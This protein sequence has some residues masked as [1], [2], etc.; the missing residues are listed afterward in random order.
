[1]ADSK[2]EDKSPLRTS[3]IQQ[4]RDLSAASAKNSRL[5]R[6]LANYT[7]VLFVFGILQAIAIAFFTRGFLL[8][9][10]VLPDIAMCSSQYN[11]TGSESCFHATPE[12]QKAVI[13]VVDALRFDFT[14]PVPGS[15]EG[16]NDYNYHNQFGVFYDAFIN[17]PENSLLLKFIAD[18]PT[19]T[20]QRLKGLTTG[21]LPTFIDAGSNFDGDTI[22]EDNLIRQLYEH[23]KRIAFAGDDT[24]T[25]MFSPYLYSNLTYPFDSLNVW[26][27]HTVDNGV[28]DNVL[29]LLEHDRQKEWDVLIGHFL[30]VD[31]CGHRYGPEHYSMKDKLNQIDEIIRKVMESLD[32]DTLLVVFGDHGMDS[33][34]NHG[35]ESDDEVEAALFMYSKKK[36]FGRLRDISNYDISENGKNYRRVNQIDIVPSL[37]LALG[38]PI[39]FNN[40]GSPIDEMFIKNPNDLKLASQLT[41]H[42]INQYRMKSDELSN[43]EVV[44]SFFANV[45]ESFESNHQ[46]QKLS[47]ERCKS[48]WATFDDVNIWIGI[49]LLTIS[50]IV[51]IVYSKLVPTVVISQLNEQC[52]LASVVLILVYCVLCVSFKLIFNPEMLPMT[53][54]VL[55]GIA[56]GIANGILAPL[57]DRYSIPFFFSQLKDNLIQNGWTYTG[58]FIIG[59]HSLLFT[60]NSFIIWEDK[61]VSFWLGTIGIMAFYKSLQN[62]NKQS[63]ILGMYHSF[64]FVLLTRIISSITICREEQGDKCST[65]FSVSWNV[66]G[67]LLILSFALPAFIKGFFNQTQSYNGMA[68]ILI[69]KVLPFMMILTWS[70]WCLEFIGNDEY[71]NK[72]F[73]L[74]TDLLD[75][76]KLTLARVVVLGSLIGGNVGWHFLP[77]CMDMK[78]ENQ[79]VP[80]TPGDAN[81]DSIIK[82]TVILL[83]LENAYG[84]SYFLF[85][86]NWIVAILCVTK[87]VGQISLILFV[88]QILTFLEL[89]EILNIRINL[90]SVVVFG[91][92]GYQQFFTTGHQATLQ[93]INW[94]SGFMLTKE[95]TF[96]LT[97]L[98]ILL[99]T[100][101]PFILIG[102]AIPLLSLW[103]ISPTQ[104]PIGLVSRVVENGTTLLIYQTFLTLSTLVMSNHFRRHLM[105]WKIFAPRFMLNSMILILLNVVITCISIGYTTFNSLKRWNIA[106]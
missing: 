32:D 70:Y 69:F 51:L 4:K 9:R 82:K 25:A 14:I 2:Q 95:I 57:I 100:F 30:G 89:V 27:L 79:I 17:Q 49:G 105:V 58:V 66:I 23:N 26:D 71:L 44:N 106:V 28:I 45:D 50:L 46:Y 22:F 8:S 52:L 75:D 11:L 72:N 36:N 53:W 40:L 10:S 78:I 102:I 6:A 91:L 64:V 84:S 12:Y 16:S 83:G 54:I 55:L 99:N 86:L 73:E 96:P 104:K 88:L 19:T 48:L 3:R 24:W 74:P 62:S 101:G 76:F 42:Q 20:L 60:S 18:P 47:L 77:L 87:P 15:I 93:A 21:S 97:H 59:C 43:D 5:D 67:L 31:H 7:R 65:N 35:G 63:M 33:T 41:S 92:L 68:P 37:A 81:S 56:L 1:M 29:P 103:K 61:I 13:L 90:I 38:V 98:T 85:L 39:P 34:G 80:I 94:E